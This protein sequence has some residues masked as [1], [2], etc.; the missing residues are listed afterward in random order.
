MDGAAVAI[1]PERQTY[2][3]PEV[4]KILGIGRSCAYEGVRTGRIPSIKIGRRVVV[5]RAVIRRM[6]GEANER[7]AA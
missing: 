7:I 4:G 5:P 6:M 1:A 3:V 2:S